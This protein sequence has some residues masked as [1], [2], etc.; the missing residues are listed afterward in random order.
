[1]K[2]REFITA[3]SLGALGLSLGDISIAAGTEN[4]PADSRKKILISGGGLNRSFLNYLTELTGK[5]KPRLCFLPTAAA[6][7]PRVAVYWY[8]LCAELNVVPFVQ[9]MFITSYYMKESF[10]DVLLS[11][12]GIIVGGGN[13]LNMLAIWKAQG[14][15]RVLYKA[16]EK[17]IVLSGGSAGSLCWFEEGT[18]DSRPKE[19]TKI[20]CLGFLEGSHSPHYD[21]E[22]ERRPMYHDLI[23][24]GILKPGYA[25]DNNAAILFIDRKVSRVI[26]SDKKSKAYYVELVDGEIRES[27]LQPDVI[28]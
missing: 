13:T 12:D 5:K 1:M 27:V 8:Q 20:E 3:G 15:D 14:I 24:S 23:K 19:L 6:D 7:D 26:A 28:L 10:E 4:Q 2:R 25:V 11:M 21:A 22:E 17:G 18:T 9:N 16:W